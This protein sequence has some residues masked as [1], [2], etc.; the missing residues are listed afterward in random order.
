M[1]INSNEI[2]RRSQVI[3]NIHFEFDK[4]IKNDFYTTSYFIKSYSILKNK[5]KNRIST[6]QFIHF[7]DEPIMMCGASEIKALLKF[8]LSKKQLRRTELYVVE[9]GTI[10]KDKN[11]PLVIIKGYYPDFMKLENIIDGIL[12]KR[13]SVA[14]NTM[15]VINNLLSHQEIIYMLDRN[16]DYFNQSY[17]AYPA[18][19]AGIDLFV[20]QAQVELFKNE[21]VKVIGTM[22]HSLIQQYQNKLPTLI[23]DFAQTHQSDNIFCLLDY[24]NN[25]LKTLNQIKNSFNLLSGVRL[26]TSSKL[27]DFSLKNTK[28]HGVNFKLVDIT[29][30]WLTENNF[31]DKKIIV[32]SGVNETFIKDINSKTTNV[33]YFG[34]GSYFNSPSVHVSADLVQIDEHHEAKHGRKLLKNFNLLKKITL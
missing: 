19:L 20:T 14:T 30:K 22:P 29:K 15:K 2:N 26:D 25:V 34:I 32:T 3:Q 11:T 6:M 18:F 23:S 10:I 1:K 27:I 8:Y 31:Q 28:L 12:S 4:K 7:A 21:N 5:F 17:D 13:C 24:E 9:D 33:D 16:I